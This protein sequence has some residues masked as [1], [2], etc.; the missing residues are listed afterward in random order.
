[1]PVPL[2]TKAE[3]LAI[4]RLAGSEAQK[5]V[6]NS[7]IKAGESFTE[8]VRIGSGKGSSILDIVLT[9]SKD[10]IEV[11]G[12]NW[13]AKSYQEGGS[14]VNSLLYK[15]GKQLDKYKGVLEKGE[16]IIVTFVGKPE[17]KNIVTQVQAFT[18]RHGAT[19]KWIGDITK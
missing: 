9:K 1:M 3:Q 8:H 2:A 11:K 4:N 15:L 18:E 5:F 16:K 12:I 6:K 10:A 19:V 13:A 14:G 7:L 17:N